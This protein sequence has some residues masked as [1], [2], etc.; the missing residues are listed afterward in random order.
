MSALYSRDA[1][2]C[3]VWEYIG[4][5][6]FGKD[7]LYIFYIDWCYVYVLV[8]DLFHEVDGAVVSVGISA[9]VTIFVREK[10]GNHKGPS[11]THPNIVLVLK[12]PLHS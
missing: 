9:L 8:V 1:G 10:I 11:A 2:Y 3:G 6:V 7:C 4:E 12:N 5:D